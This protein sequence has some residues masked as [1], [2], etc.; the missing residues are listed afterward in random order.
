M[1]QV[2]ANKFMIPRYTLFA[3]PATA[4]A[5]MLHMPELI[6]QGRLP[7]DRSKQEE[8][9]HD[10]PG[11]PPTR[12]ADLPSPMQDANAYVYNFYVK[13]AEDIQEAK[14]VLIN[15]F[16]ELEASYIDVLRKTV[17]GNVHGQVRSMLRNYNLPSST[18]YSDRFKFALSTSPQPLDVHNELR[19][20]IDM[21]AWCNSVMFHARF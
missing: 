7:I 1:R 10:I 16:Y 15:T 13:N 11:V 14:G 9:V 19:H 6:R 5:A 21:R 12:L 2:V 20:S 4:L 18:A 8:L 3:S 17:Y